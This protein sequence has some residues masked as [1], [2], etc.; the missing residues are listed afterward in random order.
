MPRGTP[1]ANI[2]K[3]LK[4]E[5]GFS[6]DSSTQDAELNMLIST[7]QKFLAGEF[8]WPFLTRR[9]SFTLPAGTRYMAFPTTED[10]PA[11]TDGSKIDFDRPC[12][13]EVKYSLRWQEVS[14]EVEAEE[15][16][17][18][19]SDRAVMVM[20]PCQKWRFA[21]NINEPTAAD[22]FEIWPIP[23]QDQSL[24]FTGQRLVQDL[25]ADEKTADLDDLLLVY[26]VAAE[27]LTRMKQPD[28]QAKGMLAKERMAQ[29]R[30]V[31][32]TR[33]RSIVIGGAHLEKPMKR[34]VPI[35]VIAG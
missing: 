14:Y 11:A 18:L 2:R 35:T 27:K 8:D 34:R 21:S 4:A 30:G 7:K 31:A 9:W 3:M 13:L 32:P 33:N 19:D 1:L 10:N 25:D 28:A 5:I 17:F 23:S 26:S 24:R 16:N 12:I 22:Q 6:Q 20:N 29:V 15:Y